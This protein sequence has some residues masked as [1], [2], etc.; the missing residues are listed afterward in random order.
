MTTQT[1]WNERT[2]HIVYGG[3]TF[4]VAFAEIFKGD[5]TDV[6][7]DLSSDAEIIDA[8]TSTAGRPYSILQRVIG[9]KVDSAPERVSLEGLD[10]AREGETGNLTLRP[11]AVFG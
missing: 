2:L 10:L 7:G 1:G 11:R 3:R 4:R 8:L 5:D 6:V 9:D